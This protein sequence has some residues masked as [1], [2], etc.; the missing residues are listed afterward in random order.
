MINKIKNFKKIVLIFSLI[1]CWAMSIG[2][3]NKIK[4]ENKIINFY[5]EDNS[6]TIEKVK[7]FK[8]IEKDVSIVGWREDSFQSVRNKKLERNIEEIKVL[9]IKGNSS[10]LLKSKSLLEDDLKGCLID[11]DT[12]YKLFGNINVIGNE[13]EYNNRNLIV[14]GIHND[15]DAN[16]VIQLLDN[17]ELN[18]NGITIDSTNLNN[19]QIKEYKNIVG[20][21]EM[22][23]EGS[24]YYSIAKIFT[25]L[26]PI[27]ALIL[28]SLKLIIGAIKVI[29]KPFFVLIYILLG[30]TSLFIFFKVTEFKISIPL[31]VIPNQWSDFEFWRT[32]FEEYTHKLEYVIN[33]KK[34]G[35]DIYNIQNL[36]K[37]MLYSTITVGLFIINLSVIKIKEFKNLITIISISIIS[38]FI[39]I[40]Y[41]YQKYSFDINI[42]MLWGVY[43]LYLI[44][45][46]YL[47]EMKK[48]D[49]DL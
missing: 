32:L 10:L 6:A 36:T 1:L 27:L 30:I 43:P 14:R 40:I 4:I 5:F 45:S 18:L 37:S 13:I 17:C 19:M 21:K 34:Y 22:P 38:T 12:A 7:E 9:S 3:A 39:V 35:T 16:I 29:K 48:L 25:F 44:G 26:F 46:Y 11:K 41:L 47:N 31:D 20:L 49:E 8:K 2:Y 33:M 23:I 15:N 28:V 24:I 42:S